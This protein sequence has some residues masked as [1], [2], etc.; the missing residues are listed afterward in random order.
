MYDS[1]RL[2]LTGSLGSCMSI[3]TNFGFFKYLLYKKKDPAF[4]GR[5]CGTFWGGITGGLGLVTKY[6]LGYD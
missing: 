5:V 2:R 3:K 1:F 4:Y 6:C